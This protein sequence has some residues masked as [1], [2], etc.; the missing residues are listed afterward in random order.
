MATVILKKQEHV[1]CITRC[2]KY[3]TKL[4]TMY[5]NSSVKMTFPDTMHLTNETFIKLSLKYVIF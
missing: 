5:Y 3:G 4:H 1:Y 2:F